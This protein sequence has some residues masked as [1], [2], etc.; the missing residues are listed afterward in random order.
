M[1]LTSLASP[2]RSILRRGTSSTAGVRQR[3]GQHPGYG[4]SWL[5]SH[6]RASIQTKIRTDIRSSVGRRW[7]KPSTNW[8]SFIQDSDSALERHQ[9]SLECQ[10]G[11]LNILKQH[12]GTSLHKKDRLGCDGFSPEQPRNS[13]SLECNS[14]RCTLLLWLVK[15][16]GRE[17]RNC[18]S[19]P[20]IL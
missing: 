11:I 2:T 1:A 16:Q 4:S 7:H 12:H 6:D 5:P 14:P 18:S 20:T 15:R 9:G 19:C 3:L 13:Q 8:E 10:E 17:L